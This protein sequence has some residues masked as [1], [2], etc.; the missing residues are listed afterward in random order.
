L[1]SELAIAAGARGMVGGQVLDIASDRPAALDY[2]VKLHR[3][4]TGALLLTACRLGAIAGH[5]SHE[6]LGAASA[7]GASVGLAFQIHDDILDV[8]SS[9]E[10]MGKPTGA[11]AAAGRHT[12]PALMGLERA[13]QTAQEEARNAC[14]AVR[15]LE[16]APGPLAALARYAVERTS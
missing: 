10:Q 6:E 9:A 3:M 2:L 16:P 15:V 8:T 7:F 4:K 13:R 14:E 5:A 11:D 1:T 12:F